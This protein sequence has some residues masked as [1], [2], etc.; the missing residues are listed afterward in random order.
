MDCNTE[1]AQ[2]GY[3][4]AIAFALPQMHGMIQKNTSIII[5]LWAQKYKTMP[6]FHTNVLHR[7]L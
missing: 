4:L 7:S 3:K 6:I 5:I 2:T 1:N